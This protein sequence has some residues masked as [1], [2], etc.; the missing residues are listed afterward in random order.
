M[1]ILL[2]LIVLLML[3]A[4][5]A[6]SVVRRR[7]T[8]QELRGDWWADFEQQF[9]AYVRGGSRSGDPSSRARGRAD[10]G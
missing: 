4:P 10:K 9:G 3:L 7:R 5:V 2:V 1:P 6:R 8:P